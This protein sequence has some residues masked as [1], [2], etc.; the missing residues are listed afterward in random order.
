MIILKKKIKGILMIAMFIAIICGGVF[1]YFKWEDNKLAVAQEKFIENQAEEMT[2][3]ISEIRQLGVLT[4]LEF[5]VDTKGCF[6]SDLRYIGEHLEEGIFFNKSICL[7]ATYVVKGTIDLEGVEIDI[8]KDK[9]VMEIDEQ[10]FNIEFY[11]I[12]RESA[13]DIGLLRKKFGVNQIE[14]MYDINKKVQQSKLNEEDIKEETI[15]N[16]IN[17]ESFVNI[18][19]KYPIELIVEKGNE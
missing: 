13:E 14:Q 16:L 4:T 3:T 8:K 12:D 17:S 9:I 2:T 1:V 19:S 10:D 5:D 15:I 6:D 18:D 7:N 11:E